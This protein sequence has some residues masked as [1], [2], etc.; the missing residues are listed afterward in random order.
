M[1]V[2]EQLMMQAD[3]RG[4]DLHLK[5]IQLESEVRMPPFFVYLLYV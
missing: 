3:S 4:N 2:H 1:S 5:V